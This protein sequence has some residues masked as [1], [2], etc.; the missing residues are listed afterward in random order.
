MTPAQELRAAAAKLR[1]TAATPLED[2]DSLTLGGPDQ[3]AKYYG[4]DCPD[5]PAGDGPWIVLMSPKLAE[6]LAA[7]LD[8]VAGGWEKSTNLFPAGDDAMFAGHPALAVARALLGGES[9]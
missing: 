1:S 6:P 7:W 4:E 5:L 2:I 8:A 9:S 3:W